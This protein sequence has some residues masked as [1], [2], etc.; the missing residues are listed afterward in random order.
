MSEEEKKERP[1]TRRLQSFSADG[2]PALV[3]PIGEG[4]IIYSHQLHLSY[5]AV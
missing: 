5:V 4:L 3:R 1:N 2:N